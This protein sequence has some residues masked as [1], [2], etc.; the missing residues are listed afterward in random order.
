[1]KKHFISTG[2]LLLGLAV[3]VMA[4]DD[5]NTAVVT[6]ATN[7]T[8]AP[9]ADASAAAPAA[10]P[11]APAPAVAD[12]SAGPPGFSS[13]QI[14][15]QRNIFDPNRV[16][17][18]PGIRVVRS[19]TPVVQTFWLGGINWKIGKGGDAAFLGS[20]APEG[21]LDVGDTINGFKIE[22]MG[23]KTV[24]LV[25]LSSSNSEVTLTLE[26]GQNALTRQDGGPWAATL[27]S[28]PA[29]VSTPR[30]QPQDMGAG[31]GGGAGAV[32]LYGGQQAYGGGYDPNAP[33]LT[34]AGGGYNIYGGA[35]GGRGGRRNRTGNGGGGFGGG[36]GG[37]GFGGGGFGGGGFGPGGAGQDTT[38][39]APAPV[40]PA[41][42][43]RLQQR[44]AASQ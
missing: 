17:Y 43:L 29:Y 37:G 39:A 24:N 5:T 16:P 44:R 27:H 3:R 31:L 1:M 12:T 7:A 25:N 42:L 38:T 41:V 13:F 2:A 26:N 15:T 19:R 30:R 33:D 32:G 22:K 23:E 28:E 14:I 20:G 36:N 21:W 34:G 18:Q 40:D 11:A 4:A 9:A 10:T 35:A 6:N 8:A